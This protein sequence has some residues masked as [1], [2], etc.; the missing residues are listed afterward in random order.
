MNRKPEDLAGMTAAEAK[1]CIFH[2]ISALKITEKKQ[3]ELARELEKWNGRRELARSRGAADLVSEAEKAA[4]RIQ[5][6]ADAAAAEIL[7]LKD[8]IEAM[9]RQ[10]PGLAAR[11]R[12]VDPD[13]LE[14]ELLIAAGHNPGDEKQ[15]AVRELEDLEKETNAGAALEAL[16]VKMGRSGASG[17]DGAP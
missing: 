9:R 6:E 17:G 4:A 11:E 3:E 7:E 5:T 15:A 13:L 12:S 16:K 8:Q 14:Q 2:F 10:L 1:E